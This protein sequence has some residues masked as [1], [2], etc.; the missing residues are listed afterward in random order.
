MASMTPKE[1]VRAVFE[2]RAPDRVPIAHISVSSRVA[3]QILGRDAYVGGG[4]NQ[5][6]EAVALWNGDDAHAEFCERAR[7]DAIAIAIALDHDV[8]RPDYWRDSRRPVARLDEHTFRYETADGSQWEVMR[9]DPVTELYSAAARSPRPELQVSDLEAVVARAEEDAEHYRPRV[10][11]FPEA[12]YALEKVGHEREVRGPGVSTS[13]PVGQ[14]AWLEATL[15]RPDLVGR[16]L[17]AQVTRSIRNAE[18]LARIGIRL[19]F[20]GG[21]FAS[22]LG[23]MYSPRVFHDL[24]LPRLERVSEACHRAGAYHLFGSDGNVWPVAED[25]YGRS[26]IDGHYELDRRAGMDIL[27]VHE[28]YPHITMVGNISSFTLHT[29]SP[30]EVAAETRACLFEAKQ[31]NKVIAGCSNIIVP[32]TPLQNVEAMLRAISECR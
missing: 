20:G 3:S 8:V 6:R 17:D 5:W 9:L 2:G 15:L 22:N 11:D 26:G 7:Q 4:M 1:R 25:L 24:M 30:A 10:E 23:P 32:E 31:T 29:G 13:I 18:V 12:C 28:R 27:K 19:F 16:Y 14:P 21:D